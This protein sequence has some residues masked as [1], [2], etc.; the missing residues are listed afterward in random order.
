MDNPN[1][2]IHELNTKV[3]ELSDKY[4]DEQLRNE[5]LSADLA[6]I[7]RAY[8]EKCEIISILRQQIVDFQT[9]LDDLETNHDALT[10]LNDNL[11][12]R[13]AFLEEENKNL[14]ETANE[15]REENDHLNQKLESRTQQTS[16]LAIKLMHT[17]QELEEKTNELLSSREVIVNL[18]Q[19]IER[20]QT[21]SSNNIN[22]EELSEENH[23]LRTKVKALTNHL[24][25]MIR[26]KEAIK[27]ESRK[28]QHYYEEQEEP[29]EELYNLRAK[30]KSLSHQL[31]QRSL[32]ED[33]AK[34]RDELHI[35][36][37][38]WQAERV[39]KER[40]AKE[41]L[42]LERK[43]SELK[44]SHDRLKEANVDL[45]KRYAELKDKLEVFILEQQ[46]IKS[47]TQDSL[48]DNSNVKKT[49]SEPQIKNHQQQHQASVVKTQNDHNVNDIPNNISSETQSYA[50]K[51]LPLGTAN[52]FTMAEEIGEIMDASTLPSVQK[53]RAI[54]DPMERA[55]E[56]AR[57]NKLQKPLHQSSYALELDTFNRMEISDDEI[58]RGNFRQRTALADYSNQRKVALRPCAFI[59]PN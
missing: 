52:N 36:E 17:K 54:Q 7:K 32:N 2:K 12:K 4:I 24:N 40:Y 42:V 27:K 49:I 25:Q 53:R 5:K 22:H 8:D 18:N 57:R 35:T 34:L 45:E 48:N 3:Q 31:S 47:S 21:K 19:A 13:N 38:S 33:I 43:L 20:N 37:T 1:K 30:V 56:L 16:D 50:K 41:N 23:S 39:H 58:K 51:R 6:D 11:K 14:V 55:N 15:L 26:E 9:G 44:K 10:N 59:I 29:I 28:E 46:N